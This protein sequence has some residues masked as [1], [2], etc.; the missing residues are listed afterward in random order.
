MKPHDFV[1]FFL[2]MAISAIIMSVVSLSPAP[3]PQISEHEQ[4][5]DI[6]E[7]ETRLLFCSA[8]GYSDAG[9]VKRV[10]FG[11]KE[12]PNTNMGYG[13]YSGQ[14][15]PVADFLP[16]QIICKRPGKI[17]KQIY[18]YEQYKRWILSIKINEK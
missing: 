17:E 3:L 15:Y 7:L 2:G 14:S 8:M 10:D 1:L 6:N 9:L 18:T 16:A 12:I 4:L 13:K 5:S 11:W